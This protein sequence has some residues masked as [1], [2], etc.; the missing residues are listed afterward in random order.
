MKYN[1]VLSS[2][3]NFLRWS[4]AF[5][6]V[7][8]H[9]RSLL[10]VEYNKVESSTIIDKIFYFFTGFGHEA[11][12]V[13]FVL[14]GYLVG[15]EFLRMSKTYQVFIIYLIKRFSR[16]FI[17]FVPALI[18]GGLIDLIGSHWINFH[19]IYDNSFHFS[20]MNFSVIDRINIEV[21]L[22]NLGMM[23]TS[24]GPTLG[25]NGPLW[26]LANE[27]W[28]YILPLLSF[29]LIKSPYI[30]IRFII[31]MI[32][33][34]L[35]YILNP[36]I[37]LYFIIWVMGMTA[38]LIHKKFPLYLLPFSFL[39]IFLTFVFSRFHIFDI[40]PFYYDLFISFSIILL[41][42]ILSEVREIP[43]PF[44]KTNSVLAD[45]SYS[46]YLFHFPFIL[47]IVAGLSFLSIGVNSQPNM[48]SYGI[49]GT[50]IVLTYLYA[51]SMYI[52]F[53]KNTKYVRDRLIS[54][55]K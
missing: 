22:I 17:V 10:F 3:L 27:W 45:Y 52:L 12:I 2:T 32:V 38:S 33:V 15:G 44:Q 46:L 51:F 13:F 36:Y 11:V 40:R 4:A 24:L 7:I 30:L 9:L 19:N 23:Q 26:S 47:I 25:S 14:S 5:L 35:L 21:L 54:W 8:G 55:L 1:P 53:E 18:I 48:I 28:Y 50:V 29:L 16:I 20:T 41:L 31:G 39:F 6:V 49:F 43:V 42:I 34:L 37:I